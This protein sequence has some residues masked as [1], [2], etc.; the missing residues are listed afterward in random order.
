MNNVKECKNRENREW[1]IRIFPNNKQLEFKNE[2]DLKHYLTSTLKQRNP[3]GRYNF[4]S[5]NRVKCIP[6][7]SWAL[8]RFEDKIIG[9]AKIKEPA[10]YEPFKNENGLSYDGY[11]IFDVSTIKVFKNPILIKDLEKW[12][13][14]EYHFKNNFKTG[15]TYYIIPKKYKQEILARIKDAEEV[16]KE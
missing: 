15:R 1:E 5:Y 6:K 13:G 3:Q 12:T 7:D 16:L 14:I 8:F 4:H 9:S 11:I 2:E 10:L